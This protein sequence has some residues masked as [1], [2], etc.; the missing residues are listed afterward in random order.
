[1]ESIVIDFFKKYRFL[2][3]QDLIKLYQISRFKTFDC[4]ELIA[5]KG[6]VY[7]YMIAIRKGVIRTYILKPNG[8]ERT[9][10]FAKENDFTTCAESAINNKPSKEFLE[11]VEET[12]VILL[13]T[14]RLKELTKSNIRLLNLWNMGLTDAFM[15]AIERVEFF[16]R[17]NPEERY[18]YLMEKDS[19]LVSRIPQKYLASFIGVSTVSL[20]RIRTRVTN[21]VNR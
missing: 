19:Q 12:K 18:I 13:E 17:F 3:M 11:A 5:G 10:R 8:E 16:V 21:R 15:E 9:V 14:N 6:E 20:S 2:H 7:P 1:M 4:G